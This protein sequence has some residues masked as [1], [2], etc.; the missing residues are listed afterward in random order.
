MKKAKYLKT[1]I[2]RLV[3]NYPIYI[4][5]VGVV[6]SLWFSLERHAFVEGF[7]DGTALGTY[8]YATYG[9]GAMIA[10]AF[11]AFSFATVYCE[12]LEYK[13]LRYSINRGSLF[14]Y[15]ISKA[16][17]IYMSS[18]VT[19]VLGSVVFILTIRLR[20][21]WVVDASAEDFMT[22]MYYTLIAKGHYWAY[23]LLGAVQMGMLAA[24]LSLAAAWVSTR[25]SNKM[26]ILVTPILLQQVLA[27]Y[28]GSGLSSV[29]IIRPD[30]Q[31][32][33]S[34]IQYFLI[35]FGYSVFFSGVLTWGIYKQLKRRL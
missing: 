26:L 6:L 22:G 28:R 5:I 18:V 34:D 14:R 21:P 35:V 2:L 23:S 3:K 17:V 10:Y 16:V 20:V 15:V 32:F 11:C 24:V 4:G 31:Q 8:F 7:F 12:D 19:M 13:Y 33:S 1:D 29:L 27:Q 30:L 9:S 25:I